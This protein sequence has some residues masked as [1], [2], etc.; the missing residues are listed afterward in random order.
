MTAALRTALRVRQFTYYEMVAFAQYYQQHRNQNSPE[1]LLK[2]FL[3]WKETEEGA[4]PNARR[5][6]AIESI[7][8][9]YYGLAL[10]DVRGKRRYTELVRARQV[11]AHICVQYQ[12]KYQLGGQKQIARVLGGKRD[13][14]QYSKTKCA[15]LMETEPL[16]RKEV[17]EIERRLVE[18]LAVIDREELAALEDKKTNNENSKTD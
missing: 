7:V 5:L 2:A 3:S 11:I 1:N 17:A 14:V 15:I 12:L 13:N 9:R 6:L 8:S 4:A 10:A 16:L 18:P